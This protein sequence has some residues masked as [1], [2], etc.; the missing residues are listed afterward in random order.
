[1][2]ALG[3]L[4]LRPV[5][6]HRPRGLLADGNAWGYL[7][8]DLARTKA[9]RWGEDGIAGLCDRYQLLC[10]A[11][12]FWNERDPH[13]KE[14][15]FG[16][17]PYEGNHGE[18]V[19]E[20]YFHVDNTPTHSY[21]C[22]L[23]KYPQAAFP[24][25]ELDRGEPAPRRP[26]SGVRAA[27]H[28]RLRRRSLLRHLHRVRQGRSGGPRDPDRGAQPRPRRRA[29]AHPAAPCG[30]ATPG[31]GARRR[32]PSR[33]SRASARTVV[34]LVD[35]RQRHAGRSQHAGA[36]PARTALPV[37]TGGAGPVHRQ[38]DQWR[39][40][41]RTRQHQPQAA[42]QGRVPPRDLRARRDGG[43]ARRLRH[44]GGAALPARGAGGRLG[45][46]APAVHRRADARR[47]STDVDAI[48]AA[49]KAEADEFYAGLATARGHRRRAA[50]AAPRAR[51]PAVEQAE[52]PLRR[53]A[54][55]RRRRSGAAAAGRHGARSATATGGT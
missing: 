22:L 4:R 8:H 39:A 53:R 36:L 37:R 9:Y 52:L 7:T 13:L 17:N 19:K 50:R 2:A 55:A 42:H 43:P 46:A 29:A 32:S 45:H 48:I 18:D 40:R 41:L 33:R 30:S 44:Q 6:G 15:L 5:V 3:A 20:Y 10:F 54:L 16:V 28:R 31:R 38:R 35:R 11:P 27:R 14:R 1:M 34:C 12:A 49:R 25:R 47:R 26:G 21:M 24:Y 51:R 23:Y